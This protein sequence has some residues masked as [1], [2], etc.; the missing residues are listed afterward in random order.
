MSINVQGPIGENHTKYF[1]NSEG[2]NTPRFC[3]TPELQNREKADQNPIKVYGRR[4]RKIKSPHFQGLSY[5]Q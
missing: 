3:S 1:S 5:W 2:Q 4:T